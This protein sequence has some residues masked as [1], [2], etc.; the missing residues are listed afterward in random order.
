MRLPLFALV[1]IAACIV[2]LY[3]FSR[4]KSD[5]AVY[6]TMLELIVNR[7][8]Y[9]GKKVSV[10]G[11]VHNQ[12]EDS[13]ISLHREDYLHETGNEFWIDLP[14]EIGFE[15]KVDAYVRVE[16]TFKAGR[17]GHMGM[18]RGAITNT[19]KFEIWSRLEKSRR[20][21]S[22]EFMEEQIRKDK[23]SEPPAN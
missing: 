1:V 19:T 16:G 7:E 10:I 17:Q 12:F 5:D 13:T 6:A 23:E 22:D 11:Y 15:N 2:S 8:D 18:F 3:G 20:Q 9:D 4:Q 14:K 21:E